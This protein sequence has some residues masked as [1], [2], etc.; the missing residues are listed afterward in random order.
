M[1]SLERASA[2]LNRVQLFLMMQAVHSFLATSAQSALMKNTWPISWNVSFPIRGTFRVGDLGR[3]A[4]QS[5]KRVKKAHS[6]G[7]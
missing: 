7:I 1:N 5:V 2:T 3:P 4:G 6:N